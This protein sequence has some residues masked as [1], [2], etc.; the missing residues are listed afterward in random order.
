MPP[1]I[2]MKVHQFLYR[3]RTSPDAVL[4]YDHELGDLG[5]WYW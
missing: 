2:E 4:H 5:A 1:S 3:I